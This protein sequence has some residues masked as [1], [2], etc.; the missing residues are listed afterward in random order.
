MGNRDQCIVPLHPMAFFGHIPLN[1]PYSSAVPS[2]SVELASARG[3]TADALAYRSVNP[4]LAPPYSQPFR[5]CSNYPP[6]LP[7][8]YRSVFATPPGPFGDVDLIRRRSL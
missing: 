1:A 2:T 7:P 4:V 3:I 5:F 6:N 8:S